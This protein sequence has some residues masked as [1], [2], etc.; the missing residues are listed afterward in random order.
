MKL[1][2]KPTSLSHRRDAEDAEEKK[3]R[4]LCALCAS[5]MNLGCQGVPVGTRNE[6]RTI[7]GDVSASEAACPEQ[8]RREA[9]SR[10]QL[11][12]NGGIALSLRSSQ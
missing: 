10:L 3:K 9:I 6:Q 7:S 5:A 1:R 8:S 12:R 2:L 4:K 11:P